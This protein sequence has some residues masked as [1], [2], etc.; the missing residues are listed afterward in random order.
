M[1]GEAT[2]VCVCV[3]VCINKV[4]KT[5][6]A[7]TLYILKNNIVEYIIAESIKVLLDR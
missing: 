2:W 4:V 5:Y 1:I 3:C 6:E 7:G